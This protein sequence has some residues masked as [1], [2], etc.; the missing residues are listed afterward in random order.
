MSKMQTPSK[1]EKR[2]V[3]SLPPGCRTNPTE[4][5]PMVKLFYWMQSCGL[6]SPDFKDFE[7]YRA[8]RNDPVEKE[9][10][11]LA[12]IE[13]QEKARVSELIGKK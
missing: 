8:R 3:Q 4:Q 7:D 5:H 1:N 12:I 13:A 6:V 9:T 11:P 10:M 2:A